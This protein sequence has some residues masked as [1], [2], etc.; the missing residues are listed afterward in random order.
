MHK[1][2]KSIELDMDASGNAKDRK[3]VHLKYGSMIGKG[4]YAQAGPG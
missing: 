4:V 2:H 3:A 1:Q